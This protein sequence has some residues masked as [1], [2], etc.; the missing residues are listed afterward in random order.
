MQAI[1]LTIGAIVG[2]SLYSSWTASDLYRRQLYMSM[3]RVMLALG[4]LVFIAGSLAATPILS[5]GQ[6]ESGFASIEYLDN[7]VCYYDEI[8]GFEQHRICASGIPAPNEREY[9]YSVPAWLTELI[10][11]QDRPPVTEPP[12]CVIDCEPG[13]PPVVTPEP[14]TLALVYVTL[15]VG[16]WRMRRGR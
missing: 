7:G 3:A 1:I 14:G 6:G 11:R 5:S 2:V 12:S 8:L 9:L 15:L 10:E 16:A 4:M 13:E